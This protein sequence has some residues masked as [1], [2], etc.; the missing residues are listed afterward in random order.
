MQACLTRVPRSLPLTAASCC[1]MSLLLSR[2]TAAV[3]QPADVHTNTQ[4]HVKDMSPS[5][6]HTIVTVNTSESASHCF[7]LAR[8]VSKTRTALIDIHTTAPTHTTSSINQGILN[9]TSTNT[10][11][12]ITNPSNTNPGPGLLI[13]VYALLP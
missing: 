6:V 7:S 12:S 11:V 2:V 13:H 9:T 5:A 10:H 3:G 4:L 1:I 8:Q